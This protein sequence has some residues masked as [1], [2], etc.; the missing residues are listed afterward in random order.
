HRMHIH[1]VAYSPDGRRIASGSQDR[2]LRV[3]DADSGTELLTLPRAEAVSAVAFSPDGRR[4]ASGEEHGPVRLWDA[5]T[6]KELASFAG[7][8][9]YV[10]S[11]KFS[12]DGRRLAAGDGDGKIWIWDVAQPDRAPLLVPAHGTLVFGIAFSPD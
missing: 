6:G 8:V 9:D 5:A 12:P 10:W 1:H 3:W 11:L 7:G 2:T 4:L